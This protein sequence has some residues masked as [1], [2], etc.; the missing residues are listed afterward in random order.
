MFVNYQ[1]TGIVAGPIM[2]GMLV[3]MAD[4]QAGGGDAA[5]EFLL[6]HEDLWTGWVSADAAAKIKAA[7]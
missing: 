5:I 2:N 6:K 7:L 4:E 1:G 3:F